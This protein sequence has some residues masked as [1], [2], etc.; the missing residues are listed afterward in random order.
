MKRV[1]TCIA[2]LLMTATVHAGVI[3][4]IPGSSAEG[5]SEGVVPFSNSNFQYLF[6]LSDAELQASGLSVGE[7]ITGVAWRLGS[8]QS[9]SGIRNYTSFQIDAGTPAAGIAPGNLSSTFANNFE[10]S[11]KQTVL[12]GPLAYD[13]G[14]LPQGGSP[15]AY[16]PAIDFDTP[17]TYTGNGLVF[18]VIGSGG[19]G[20]SAYVDLD[21]SNGT[22]GASREY[23]YHG[24][25]ATS[26]NAQGTPNGALPIQFTTADTAGVPEPSTWALLTLAGVGFGG[27]QIRKRSSK[28]DEKS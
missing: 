15:N 25:S 4:P 12:S 19:S 13:L 23:A 20:G 27:Y 9:A 2:V 16:G 21:S 14:Q 8:G 17:L 28:K 7:Q 10:G 5:N 6:M 26:T 24:S 3:E 22:W 1:L 18:H 11:D